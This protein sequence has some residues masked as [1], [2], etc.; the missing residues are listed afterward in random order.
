MCSRLDM[1]PLSPNSRTSPIPC[2]MEGMSIGRVNSIVKTERCRIWERFINQARTKA[3]DTDNR[4][5]RMVVH[6]ELITIG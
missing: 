3:S 6:K 2:D 4:V 5:A 1:M